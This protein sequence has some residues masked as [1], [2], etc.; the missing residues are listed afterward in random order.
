M[1][2]RALTGLKIIDLSRILA[3]PWCTQNLADRGA[4]VIK[5]EHPERGDDTRQWG[6]PFLEDQQTGERMSACFSCCNRVRPPPVGRRAHRAQS[7]AQPSIPGSATGAGTTVAA[8]RPSCPLQT[9]APYPLHTEIT[10]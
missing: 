8:V 3:G 7:H 2:D 4:E 10:P 9:P 6:P 5:I 1:L